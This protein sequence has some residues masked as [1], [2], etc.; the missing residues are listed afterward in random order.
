MIY[1]PD[2][3]SNVFEKHVYGHSPTSS[4][5]AIVSLQRYDPERDDLVDV[6]IPKIRD[7]NLYSWS[8]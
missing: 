3:W 2:I 1:D 7:R 5:P 4:A 6:D 8:G